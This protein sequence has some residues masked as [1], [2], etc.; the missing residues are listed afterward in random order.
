MVRTLLSQL[1]DT[2]GIE[3]KASHPMMAWCIRHACWLLNRFSVRR[4]TGLTPYEATKMHP[5]QNLKLVPSENE[6]IIDLNFAHVGTAKHV[7][8]SSRIVSVA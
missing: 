3:L 1:K 7:I 8:S 2:M 5:Y 6:D 4:A